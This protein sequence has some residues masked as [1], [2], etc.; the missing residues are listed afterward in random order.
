MNERNEEKVEYLTCPR[1]GEKTLHPEMVRNSLSRKDNETYICDDC[2][3]AEALE[4][5]QDFLKRG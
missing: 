4:E 1:C 3:T 2:G 5:M